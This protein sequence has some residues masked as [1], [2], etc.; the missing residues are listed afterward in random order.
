MSFGVRVMSLQGCLPGTVG[1]FWQMIWQEN[2]RVI[3]MTTN[4][5]E[6][7]RVSSCQSCHSIYGIID[8]VICRT[9][10]HVTGQTWR[11]QRY[12]TL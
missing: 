9:S 11:R 3:V 7:G 12:M 1:D 6:R 10:A 5:V 8:D 4:E 2:S